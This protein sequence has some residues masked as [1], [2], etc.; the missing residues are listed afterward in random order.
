MIH[1]HLSGRHSDRSPLSYAAL[2]PLFMGQIQM[3]P[4]PDGADLL[5]YSH[6]LDI[7]D[8]S[9]VAHAHWRAT[10]CPIVLLSEEPFWDTIWG[11]KPL[12]K[13]R[14]LI[15]P[16]GDVPVIQLNH[17]TSDIFNFD[18]I[19]Y[20]LL[21]NLR[22]AS[23]YAHRF[24]R[25]AAKRAA[26]WRN[27]F[28]NYPVDTSFMAVQRNESYHNVRFKNGGII[29]LCAWR[30]E[31][32]K[33]CQKGVVKRLGQSWDRNW[34]DGKNRFDLKDWHL[35]KLTGQDRRSRLFSALENT[36]QPNYMSEKLFDAFA[37]GAQPIYFAAPDH[38]VHDLGLPAPSWINL[39]DLSVAKATSRL[40]TAQFGPDFFEAYTQ[41]Q[42]HLERL[43]TDPDVIIR[44]RNRLKTAVVRNLTDLLST[45]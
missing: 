36:H 42:Q 37:I 40:D 30:S 24:R 25:N 21:T 4:T 1:I 16:F 10:N 11:K 12:Q 2:A 33:A 23:A 29:G 7:E 8:M 5:V 13:S 14:K 31:L 3:L 38:R 6:T 45:A 41:A 22:F 27:D 26:D 19:P 20:Y 34:N 39:F 43:F 15:T 28:A 17:H 9:Q 44:E 32:A 18:Q 35:D